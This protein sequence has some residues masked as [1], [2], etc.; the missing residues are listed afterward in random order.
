[1]NE[2]ACNP[3]AYADDTTYNGDEYPVVGVSWQDAD[4]YCRWAGA[5][6]PTEAQWEYAAR[7]DD[8]R[9]YPWGDAF[10]GSKANF[11]DTN[12]TFDWKDGEQDDGH[13]TTAPAGSYS[14]AGDSWVDAADMGGNVWEWTADWYSDYPDTPQINPTGPAAGEW[15]VLRGG[16]WRVFQL[17]LRAANRNVFSPFNR[18]FIAG[19]R[20]AVA[21]GS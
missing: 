16:S 14:P 20:C 6:L 15:K 9:I 2:E 5:Q 21:P 18:Y 19:F 7:G 13:E 10:D 4:K 12:C 3:S 17:Y 1:M 8:G 11:C